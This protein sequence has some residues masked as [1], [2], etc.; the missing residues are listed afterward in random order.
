MT[1]ELLKLIPGF[2]ERDGRLLVCATNFVRALDPAFLRHGRFDYVIPDRRAGRRR[3]GGDLA[4]LHPGGVLDRIDLDALV[5][6][7]DLFTPAD[8]EFAAR[9]GSQRALEVAVYG[10]SDA[11]ATGRAVR[12]P[13]TTS[14]P[15]PRRARR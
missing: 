13:P 7:S 5:E 8:I 15:S 14:P 11:S 2:R 4:A 9:K 12:R 6:A 10:D 3:A 1:N